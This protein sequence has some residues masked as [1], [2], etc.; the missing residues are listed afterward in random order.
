PNPVL[1]N[2]SVDTIKTAMEE[3]HI[4]ILRMKPNQF[5]RHACAAPPGSSV[6]HLKPSTAGRGFEFPSFQNKQVGPLT[7]IELRQPQPPQ[8]LSNTHPFANSLP[9]TAKP[10]RQFDQ[11]KRFDTITKERSHIDRIDSE[12]RIERDDS[13]EHLPLGWAHERPVYASVPANGCPVPIMQAHW[14]LEDCFFLP[15]SGLRRKDEIM[16]TTIPIHTN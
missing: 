7:P 11:A 12:V 15:L 2:I 3:K 1:A 4:P 14:T 13:R 9:A 10:R 8:H 16:K 5:Q 6:V